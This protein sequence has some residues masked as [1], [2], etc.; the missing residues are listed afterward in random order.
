MSNYK[1]ISKNPRTAEW[2]EADWLDDYFGRHHY[3]VRFPNGVVYDAEKENIETAKI[4]ATE[5][6]MEKPPMP[7]TGSLD[8]YE[9]AV[10]LHKDAYK[11]DKWDKEQYKDHVGY[12]LQSLFGKGVWTFKDLNDEQLR[13]IIQK[14]EARL[15]LG[16]RSTWPVCEAC[17]QRVP[18]DKRNSRFEAGATAVGA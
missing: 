9:K 5:P 10:Q 8:L 15:V 4:E 16:K 18:P 11:K 2:E 6:K 13:Y 3:G 7:P 1:A 17:G 14:S 12:K